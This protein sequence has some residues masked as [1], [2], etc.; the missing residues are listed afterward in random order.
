[1]RTFRFLS[2]PFALRACLL[3]ALL[4]PVAWVY[5]SGL[6]I[7]D[8]IGGRTPKSHYFYGTNQNSARFVTNKG[9]YALVSVSYAGED[10]FKDRRMP[11]PYRGSF[12]GV[13]TNALDWYQTVAV[14]IEVYN[15]TTKQKIDT[16]N[17]SGKL[18]QEPGVGF[19][20]RCKDDAEGVTPFQAGLNFCYE[21]GTQPD[22]PA[23]KV[24][25]R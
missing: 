15:S 13:T 2:R 8:K 23:V 6:S 12:G 25:V 18:T 10:L 1:M 22:A 14:R 4:A 7:T 5:G 11:G 19:I 21:K 3:L 24:Y 20:Y 17:W 9:Y 16:F